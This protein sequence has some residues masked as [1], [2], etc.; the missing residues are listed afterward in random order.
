VIFLPASF[1]RIAISIYFIPK[2][3]FTAPMSQSN[4]SHGTTAFH[5]S[6]FGYQPVEET[7]KEPLVQAVFD[8]VAARYDIMNDVM[9]MGMH[10]HWKDRLMDML[11]P[12]PEMHLLDVAGGTGDVAFRFLKRGGGQVTISDLNESMLKVGQTRAIDLN[13]DATRIDWVPA[14]A[15]ALPFADASVNAYTISFGIR[16][17]THLDN[18]LS[19]AYRVLKH[20]GR[21]LCLEFSAPSQPWLKRA[22]DAYS[23]RVIPSI[24]AAITGDK[25]AYA[26]LVESIR[27][28]P[29]PDAFAELIR[30]AGF[31]NVSYRSLTSGVVA[32]HS[33]W[34]V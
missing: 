24:G 32:I 28:F 33:G 29:K 27:Q 19:E 23:F 20:G 3:R 18:A 26:Y 13:L 16:N 25:A 14:N 31:S 30:T 6:H 2:T 5:A 15:E 22:Y 11:R 12:S 7:D 34:K 21:F 10:H 9:S 17:V 1:S 8:T 4:P